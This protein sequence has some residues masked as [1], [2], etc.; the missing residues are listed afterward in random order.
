MKSWQFR[1]VLLLGV[2]CLAVGSAIRSVGLA[3]MPLRAEA[4]LNQDRN[5][6]NAVLANLN[7]N[8][9]NELVTLASRN[10]TIAIFLM[11]H[12][13]FITFNNPPNSNTHP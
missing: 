1:S 2:A 7:P 8:F 13:Y 5:D 9:V 12:G 11:G 10:Q 6:R 4:Q 3:D